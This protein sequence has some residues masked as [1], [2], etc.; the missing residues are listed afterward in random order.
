MITR[1]HQTEDQVV[2]FAADLAMAV[3]PGD[4][5]L[6]SGDLGA[7]KTTFARA[8][9]RQMAELEELE[10]PSPTYTISQSYDTRVPVHHMDLY[11]INGLDELEETGWTDLAETGCVLMEWP[12]NC[13]DEFPENAIH[14]SIV[15]DGLDARVL[16]LKAPADTLTRIE[17]SF[18]IRAFLDANGYKDCDRKFLTGDASARAYETIGDQDTI[19]MNAPAMPDGPPVRDGK[20][21]SQIAKLAED[22]SAFVGVDQ[23]LR[24]NGLQAPEIYAADV[25][26]GL[27]LTE[28]FG[29]A[30]I[31]DDK[32]APIV[33]RYE[34]SVELLA[35]MHGL[36]FASKIEFQRGKVHTIPPYDHEAMMI[37]AELLL[38]WYIPHETSADKDKENARFKQIWTDLIGIVSAHPKT[39]TLRDYHSPNIIWMDDNSGIDRVG[40]IDFQD[41]VLGPQAYDVASVIQDARVDV[42]QDLETRLLDHYI[43]CR[44]GASPDF[45]EVEFRASLAIM[46]AQRATKILGIFVRLDVRDGKPNYRVHIP[47]MLDYLGRSIKHPV[48]ADYRDWLNTVMEL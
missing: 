46:A 43:K 27:L 23:L 3:K 14:L 12:E 5:I 25:D 38:D 44:K 10:V 8:F 16:T 37:E 17:R 30:T 47:R 9:I 19:M 42:S 32:R 36:E 45:D 26:N 40:L 41:A 48:L 1:N 11:R 39:I 33:E 24:E 21:Y 4:L 22:V 28:N 18:E 35:H 31:I 15:Q 6:L 2:R 29:A 7:G 20:P 13:F 34:A